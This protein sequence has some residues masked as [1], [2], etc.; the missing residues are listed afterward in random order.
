MKIR[1]IVDVKVDVYVDREIRSLQWNYAVTKSR[2]QRLTQ[3]A[4]VRG[5]TSPWMRVGIHLIRPS[6]PN[7][8]LEPADTN[9]V[10]HNCISSMA[11]Q[12]ALVKLR[13][14]LHFAI[15]HFPC[16]IIA[17]LAF[18]L[19]WLFYGSSRRNIKVTLK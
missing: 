3:M 16:R 9:L 14:F 8:F 11:W 2:Y 4:K 15:L 7:Y 5:K 12:P 19:K 6:R 18:C 1:V 13:S 10:Q 17:R